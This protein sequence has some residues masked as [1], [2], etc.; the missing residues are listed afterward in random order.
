MMA[1]LIVATLY[2]YVLPFSVPMAIIT[3][4]RWRKMIMIYGQHC[5]AGC[6]WSS[7]LYGL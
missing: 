4:V 3:E 7:T 5:L 2:E 1:L 6:L